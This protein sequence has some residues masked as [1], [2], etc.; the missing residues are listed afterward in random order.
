[1]KEELTP[2]L[3]CPCPCVCVCACAAASVCILRASCP[4]MTCDSSLRDEMMD[5]REAS[6]R[7]E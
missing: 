1:M 7:D 4:S 5:A 2:T 3:P 6:V